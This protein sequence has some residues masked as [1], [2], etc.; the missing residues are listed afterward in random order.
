VDPPPRNRPDGGTDGCVQLRSQPAIDGR[1]TM[2][3]RRCD[4]NEF[5]FQYQVKKL[6]SAATLSRPIDPSSKS[7]QTVLERIASG[8]QSA[9]I[10][11]IDQYGGLIWTLANRFLASSA[12]AE[13]VT[14]EIFIELWQKAY[15]FD[16]SLASEVTF[17]AMV[18]RRRLIDHARRK[19]TVSTVPLDAQTVEVEEQARVDQVELSDEAAKAK[20]CLN[21]LSAD[22]RSVLTLSIQQGESHSRIAELM[23]MPLGTVKSFARRGLLQLR[24]C[25]KRNAAVVGGN[26]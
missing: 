7:R 6:M 17:V 19:T 25:M 10:E 1:L 5:S 18:A 13:D 8:E 12:D 16:S 20:Q 15:A 4:G 24:D 3:G 26:R 9:L 22:Q 21:K 11:C 23:R 14:Q 2:S